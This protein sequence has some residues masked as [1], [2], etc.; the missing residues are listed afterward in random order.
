MAPQPDTVRTGVIAIVVGSEFSCPILIWSLGTC[1]CA[2]RPPSQGF[3]EMVHHNGRS[4]PD[5]L[6]ADCCR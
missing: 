1:L 4:L 3:A 2:S 6:S 5:P